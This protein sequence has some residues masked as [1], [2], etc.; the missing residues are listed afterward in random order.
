MVNRENCFFYSPFTI[1]HLLLPISG[2]ALANV[3]ARRGGDAERVETPVAPFLF[4][5]VEGQDVRGCHLF[6]QRLKERAKI[7]FH[8]I[9]V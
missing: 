2:A 9:D 3:E 4:G 8:R 6:G 7:F 1:H 5:R